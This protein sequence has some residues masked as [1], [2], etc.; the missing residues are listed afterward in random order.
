MQN[1]S[2]YSAK[3]IGKQARKYCIQI[4]IKDLFSQRGYG[5]C[6]FPTSVDSIRDD[7]QLWDLDAYPSDSCIDAVQSVVDPMIASNSSKDEYDDYIGR[8]V[9]DVLT[10]QIESNIFNVIM[11]SLDNVYCE[12]CDN[13]VGNPLID[14]IQNWYEHGTIN[15]YLSQKQVDE[16]LR[17]QQL[18]MFDF[19]YD[20]D[21]VQD[22]LQEQARE[23]EYLNTYDFDSC[24][25]EWINLDRDK[26][27]IIECAIDLSDDYN[28]TL[29]G[30]KG[31]QLTL[32]E[33]AA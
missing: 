21:Q 9:N 27:F 10:M 17:V 32:I 12:F 26:T 19:E 23:K 28:I 31:E 11:N 33:D 20:P 30:D 1:L 18:S 16:Y 13:D 4:D 14:D 2:I 29:K 8:I 15:F 7:W 6:I 22:Y 3:T 25:H 24:Y 5:S